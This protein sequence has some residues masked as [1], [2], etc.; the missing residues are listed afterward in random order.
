M[1]SKPRVKLC[2]KPTQE[3]QSEKWTCKG[4]QGGTRRRTTLRVYGVM[5]GRGREGLKKKR[6]LICVKCFKE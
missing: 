6:V 2:R 3:M 1:E 5:K 4:D